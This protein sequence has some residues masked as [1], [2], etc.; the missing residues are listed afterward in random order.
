MPIAEVPFSCIAMDMVGPLSKSSAGHQYLLVL[1]DYATRFPEAVPMQSVTGPQV[2]EELLK[3]IT[4][5]GILKEI[6]MDQGSN[7]MLGVL[8]SLCET[9]QIRHLCTTVYHPQTNRVVERFN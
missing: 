8:C 3:W 1:I 6:V 9:L 2:A 5:V 7:F 4:R